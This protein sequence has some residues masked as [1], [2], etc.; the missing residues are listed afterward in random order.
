MDKVEEMITQ[1]KEF[2]KAGDEKR[3]AAQHAAGKNT[4]RERVALLFDAGSFTEIETL[5][6][7][8]N[9]VA[10]FG[11]VHGRAVYCFAQDYTSCGGAMTRSQAEK[12]KKLLHMAQLTGAPVVA[13]V[14]SAGVK[15]TEGA[16]ALPAYAEIFSAMTRLSGVCPMVCCVMG[17][18][19]GIATLLTQ[20]C[21]VTVQVEKTGTVALHAASVMNSDLSSIKTEE[22]LFGAA[23]MAKQGA[24][25]LTCQNEAEAVQK[26]LNVLD[27]LPG[28]NAE[29]AP[30]VESDDLNRVLTCVDANEAMALVAD[31]ADNGA[32]IELYKEFGKAAHTVLCHVGGHSVGVVATDYAVDNGRLDA[33]TCSKIARFV[34]MCDC[35]QLPILTLVNTDGIAVPCACKQAETLRGAA[36]MLYAY[37]EATAPKAAVI[38]G[39]AIGAAYV[40]MGGKAIADVCY[41][42]PTAVVAPVTRQVAVAAFDDEKLNA[43]ESREALEEEYSVKSGAL[44]AAENALVDEV[45]EPQDTRKVLINAVEFLYSKR[46]VNPPKKHGNMPL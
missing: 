14:D 43:G 3:T 46:D 2:L 22:A 4:A 18:C 13:M 33:D 41:A 27:A 32:C 19:T 39:N 17:P 40:A 36:Q 30:L 7:D 38:T 10:G 24:V 20:V 26:V 11:T 8:A 12:V 16:A 29:D 25:A 15:V 34:R 35:Y 9:V 44:N 28:C 45:I 31:V 21:D 6:K 23:T 1:A 5:R 42:W 37:A